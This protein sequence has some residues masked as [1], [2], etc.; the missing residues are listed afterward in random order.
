LAAA[1]SSWRWEWR[2]PVV[3]FRDGLPL[4]LLIFLLPVSVTHSLLFCTVVSPLMVVLLLSTMM[5]D[6]CCG[7]DK[8]GWRWSPC[9]YPMVALFFIWC[10]SS[11]FSLSL[12]RFPLL[13]VL[14]LLSTFM[15]IILLF[16]NPSEIIN[17]KLKPL[18]VSLCK[19]TVK[20]WAVFFFFFLFFLFFFMFLFFYVFF[21]FSMPLW[22]F[23]FLVFCLCFFV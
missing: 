8:E 18:G 12:L 9:F 19:S 15:F 11:S 23:F 1:K 4:F 21:S 5:P 13:L 14:S 10:C 2:R 3:K 6:S 7:R 22:V 20:R 17:N 16:C